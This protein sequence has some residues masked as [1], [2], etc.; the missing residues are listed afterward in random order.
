VRMRFLLETVL[1]RSFLFCV[2]PERQRLCPQSYNNE[3]GT[4]ECY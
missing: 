1:E 2:S 3:N 4:D